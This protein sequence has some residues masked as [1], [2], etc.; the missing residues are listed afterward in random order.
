MIIYEIPWRCLKLENEV[1]GLCLSTAGWV[2]KSE[3]FKLFYSQFTHFTRKTKPRVWKIWTVNRVS[4]LWQVYQELF[5]RNRCLVLGIL[6][7]QEHPIQPRSQGSREDYRISGL[8]LKHPH[9][10]PCEAPYVWY[11]DS[12]DV[13]FESHELAK[14]IFLEGLACFMVREMSSVFKGVH[15][16]PCHVV[17]LYQECSS[18]VRLP[19]YPWPCATLMSW[20]Y[21]ILDLISHSGISLYGP[22]VIW[23][24]FYIVYGV[25]NSQSGATINLLNCV[26][27]FTQ[28]LSQVSSLF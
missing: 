18:L 2:T 25:G 20:I 27:F 26:F 23:A 13:W 7:C 8:F 19:C 12:E 17:Q 22:E 11:S 28:T 10:Y 21:F 5:L 15:V 3:S 24:D 14:P 4:L 6:L 1:C 9:T 16:L